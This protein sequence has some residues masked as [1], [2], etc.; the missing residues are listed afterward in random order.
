MK[1]AMHKQ[2]GDAGGEHNTI[3]S[4]ENKFLKL[5][6]KRIGIEAAQRLWKLSREVDWG[7]MHGLRPDQLNLLLV[8]DLSGMPD[9]TAALAYQKAVNEYANDIRLTSYSR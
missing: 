9:N 6:E 8:V 2:A 4:P 7:C 3:D 1:W 5:V